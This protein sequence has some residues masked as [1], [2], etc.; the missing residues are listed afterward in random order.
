MELYILFYLVAAIIIESSSSITLMTSYA[1]AFKAT[2]IAR[3]A[4]G[5]L[6]IDKIRVVRR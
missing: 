1:I 4:R 2:S 6:A 5:I 3:G